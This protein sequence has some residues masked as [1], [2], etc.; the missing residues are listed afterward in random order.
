MEVNGNCRPARS[1][2][3]EGFVL[4]FDQL[5]VFFLV[6]CF[7]PCDLKK[8]MALKTFSLKCVSACDTH[9]GSESKMFGRR[10]REIMRGLY[11]NFDRKKT[12]F[13]YFLVLRGKM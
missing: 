2:D 5:V 8:C 7:E 6:M 3:N 13:L 9:Y 12:V 4:N 10:V 1:C 11:R